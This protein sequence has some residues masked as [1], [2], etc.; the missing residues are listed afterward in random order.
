MLLAIWGIG[1][2]AAPAT[3]P[4]IIAYSIRS[5]PCLS[6]QIFRVKTALVNFFM[7][8]LSSWTNYNGTSPSLPVGHRTDNRVYDLDRLHGHLRRWRSSGNGNPPTGT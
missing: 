2:P 7:I 8:P 4:A 6:F 3:K 5:W 1:A